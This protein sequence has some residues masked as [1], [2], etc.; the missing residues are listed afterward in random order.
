MLTRKLAGLSTATLAVLFSGCL[1]DGKRAVETDAT[2]KPAATSTKLPPM[3][4][5]P[6]QLQGALADKLTQVSLPVPKSGEAQTFKF[7][8]GEYEREAWVAKLPENGQ[9]VSV[10]YANGKIFVGGGFDSS[11]MYALDAKTGKR[12][13]VSYNLADPGPTAAV[14]DNDELAFDTFSCSLAVLTAST[15]KVLWQKWIGSETPTQPAFTKDFVL[16]PHP[17]D[18]GGFALSA[19]KRKTGADAWHASIDGHGM[20]APIVAGDYVY[21]TTTNGTLYKFDLKGKRQWSQRIN[22]LSAP[23]IDGDEIH[24]A[25]H[26]KSVESQIVLSAADGKRLR[27]V[28][29]AKWP[30]DAPGDDTHAIWS[31]E[32]SRPVVKDGI[33][34]TA[35]GD[36][37]EARDARTNELHWERDHTVGTG[38]RKVTSVIAA[39]P[40]ALITSRDGHIVALDAKTGMKRFGYDFDATITAQPV[41]AEGWM[42]VATSRGQVFAFDL[43]NKAID[44]WHMWGGNAQHNL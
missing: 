37:V 29:S 9:L 42:Y 13:W 43:G 7:G 31:Y 12:Q 26:E 15:G 32:G 41:I 6:G 21:V 5:T 3:V 8:K 23:W 24:V 35:M 18:D 17:N 22:A 40:L 19:Y 4:E 44:G 33:R 1:D 2:P 38:A 34:F 20:T 30:G 25:V 28:T 39:G 36:R 16:A 11:A 10:A 27:T 14:V